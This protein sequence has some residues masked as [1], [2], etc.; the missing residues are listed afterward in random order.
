MIISRGVGKKRK[1]IEKDFIEKLF[2]KVLA[3]RRE[4][5]LRHI[6]V[7]LY[8]CFTVVFVVTIVVLIFS[9]AVSSH[10]HCNY[11]VEPDW[12]RLSLHY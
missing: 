4:G 7:L 9:M 6:V 2:S 10:H 8:A 3:K 11:S 1:I 12:H 5:G